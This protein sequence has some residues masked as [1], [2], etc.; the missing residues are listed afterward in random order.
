MVAKKPHLQLFFYKKRLTAREL[1]VL[2]VQVV[3][4]HF[5]VKQELRRLGK[6]ICELLVAIESR[7]F[8]IIFSLYKR[9]DVPISS[10]MKKAMR[11]IPT[12]WLWIKLSSIGRDGR[13]I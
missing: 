7:I 12:A 1:V 2:L 13:I 11:F 8:L 4:E 3:M 5:Q 6:Q 10:A 9:M